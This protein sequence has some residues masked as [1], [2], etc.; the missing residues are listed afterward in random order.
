MGLT[1]FLINRAQASPP[2]GHRLPRPPALLGILLLAAVT[3]AVK[4]L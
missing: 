2:A 3:L 4:D 1:L